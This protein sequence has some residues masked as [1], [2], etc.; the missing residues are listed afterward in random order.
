MERRLRTRVFNEARDKGID[1]GAAS[2]F[3][4]SITI[5]CLTGGQRDLKRWKR[6]SQ[7]IEVQSK[8]YFQEMQEKEHQRQQRKEMKKGECHS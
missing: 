8:N 3:L 6:M 2:T 7:W 5:R 4:N 1:R